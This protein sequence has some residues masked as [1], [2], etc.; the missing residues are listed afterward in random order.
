M[1]S[2][3]HH[4]MHTLVV[5]SVITTMKILREVVYLCALDPVM[6]Y[7]RHRYMQIRVHLAQRTLHNSTST[8][9]TQ[10]HDACI[11]GVTS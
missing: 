3:L 1:M 6:L 2:A 8:L 10:T 4:P 11:V 9:A 5:K 7:Q